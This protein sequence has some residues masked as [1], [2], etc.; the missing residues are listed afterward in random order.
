M[1]LGLQERVDACKA[2]AEQLVIHGP[3]LTTAIAVFQ[4]QSKQLTHEAA[5]EQTSVKA[6]HGWLPPL[7]GLEVQESGTLLDPTVVV[8]VHQTV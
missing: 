2:P 8:K 3:G 4:G 7:L 6:G 1:F 5:G